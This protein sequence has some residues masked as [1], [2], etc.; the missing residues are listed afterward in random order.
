MHKI[1]LDPK[2]AGRRPLDF[3][4]LDPRKTALIVI[5]MQTFFIDWPGGMPNPHAADIIGNINALAAGLRAAGGKV[6]FTQHAAHDDAPFKAPDWQEK[7]S[8]ALGA[9]NTRLRPGNPEFDLHPLIEALPGDERITKY[10]PSAFHPLSAPGDEGG[11]KRRL[12]EAGIDTLIITGTLTN[13]CCESTARDA[14][15]HNFKLIFPSDASAT[16]SD[17]EHNATLLSMAG[18]FAHVLSTAAAVDILARSRVA[19]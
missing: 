6:I 11:F 15:Q 17:A 18:L 4:D 5:D 3:S 13:G 12:T 9:L 19:A 10:R 1:D 14:W 8:A 7:G 16:L 2:I